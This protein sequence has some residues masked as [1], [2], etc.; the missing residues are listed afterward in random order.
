MTRETELNT[1]MMAKLAGAGRAPRTIIIA[2]AREV[3]I[4]EGNFGHAGSVTTFVD[5]DA[6]RRAVQ[7]LAPGRVLVFTGEAPSDD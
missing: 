4:P 3:S 6:V 7:R 1:A 5:Y 2:D